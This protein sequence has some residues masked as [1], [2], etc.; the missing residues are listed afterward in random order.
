MLEQKLFLV[1]TGNLKLDAIDGPIKQQ[2]PTIKVSVGDV[3]IPILIGPFDSGPAVS[4]A[5]GAVGPRGGHLA[6]VQFNFLNT[7]ATADKPY[8]H[9]IGHLVV[10]CVPGCAAEYGKMVVDAIDKAYKDGILKLSSKFTVIGKQKVPTLELI[11]K[12]FLNQLHELLADLFG[13]LIGGA[14]AFAPYY[15][16]L[17]AAINAM[18]LGGMDNVD[19]VMGNASSYRIVK[20]PDGTYNVIEAHPQDIVRSGDWQADTA[21]ETDFPETAD[22]LRD[23]VAQESGHPAPTDIV[24]HGPHADEQNDEGDD[25]ADGEGLVA[26][27]RRAKTKS[28][29]AK[30]MKA[31]RAKKTSAA[32]PKQ[33]EPPTISFPRADYAAGCRVLVPHLLDEPAKCFNG[34]TLKQLVCLTPEMMKRKVTP[35]KELIKQGI[36]KLPDDGAHY[37]FHHVTSAATIA[38][39]ELVAEGHDPEESLVLVNRAA[40][41]MMTEL[42]GPWEEQKE[43]HGLYDIPAKDLQPECAHVKPECDESCESH[44][45]KCPSERKE[46]EKAPAN[47]GEKKA[48]RAKETPPRRKPGRKPPRRGGSKA[49]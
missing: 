45:G 38:F 12:I 36:G 43:K 37:F 9:E 21:T 15:A 31:A 26:R 47:S 39:F 49:A 3:I 44:D 18:A 4:P 20:G 8:D 17:I 48:P 41:E 19:H 25:A 6:F 30:K 34:L 35:L 23:L 27:P 13:C 7:L 28:A 22:W 11:K 42:L 29:S 32:P 24:W 1:L 33:V 5:N 40:E 2:I 16:Y 46:Q 14:P 10:G